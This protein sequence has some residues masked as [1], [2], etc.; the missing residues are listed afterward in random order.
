M[1]C[2]RALVVDFSASGGY[3]RG[4]VGTGGCGDRCHRGLQRAE[5]KKP[6]LKESWIYH[7]HGHYPLKSS[8]FPLLYDVGLSLQ[9]VF[10]LVM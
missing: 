2:I 10:N 6:I 8:L 7:G 5:V 4:F 9:K 3:H 1:P